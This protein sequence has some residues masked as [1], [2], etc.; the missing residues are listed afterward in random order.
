MSSKTE[1]KKEIPTV[2][3]DPGTG[4]TYYRGNFLGKVNIN[5]TF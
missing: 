4:E 3:K 1:V 2:L 5:R